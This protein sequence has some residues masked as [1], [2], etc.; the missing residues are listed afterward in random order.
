V[1]EI[2][3][4]CGDPLLEIVLPDAG[5]DRATALGSLVLPQL[6][7]LLECVRSARDVERIERNDPVT[8]LLVCAS[9]YR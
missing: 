5:A 3:Q 2:G 1:V 6:E 7:C 9:V 8:E 4:L